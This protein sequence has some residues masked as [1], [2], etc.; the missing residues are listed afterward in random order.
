M[1]MEY[2]NG[3]TVQYILGNGKIINLMEKGNLLIL[4]AIIT[5]GNGKITK[6]METEFIIEPMEAIM[7]VIGLMISPMVMV[8]R[9]GEMEISTKDLL[10]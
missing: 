2:K 8:L 4:M 10:S 3:L 1:A 6:Q 5:K 9:N 7:M